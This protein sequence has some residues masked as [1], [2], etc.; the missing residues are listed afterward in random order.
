MRAFLVIVIATGAAIAAAQLAGATPGSGVLSA[1]MLVRATFGG[2]LMLQAKPSEATGL[3]WRGRNW[4]PGQVPEF[5]AMLRDQGKVTD[6]GAWLV[7]HPAVASKL[8]LPAV[9]KVAGAEFAVQQVTIAPGGTTGWH[10]HPG[11]VLVLVKS[12]ELTLY[13]GNDKNCRGTTYKAGQS[14]VDSGFGHVHL[15]RN[16]GA[17]NAEFYPVYLAP[18]PAG[19]PLR[20]DAP[21]PGTC[22]F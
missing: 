20:I 3:Q 16:E 19:Q 10:T 7:D 8:G 5:L 18:A 17:S 9:R 13:D 22:S 14:F 15:A 21:S 12:G 4:Q 6:L 1:P 2:D 11:P